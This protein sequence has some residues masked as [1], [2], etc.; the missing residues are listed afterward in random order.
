MLATVFYYPSVCLYETNFPYEGGH[1]I[2]RL[3]FKTCVLH[4]KDHFGSFFNTKVVEVAKMLL[5]LIVVGSYH[6]LRYKCKTTHCL[7]SRTSEYISTTV[8]GDNEKL[9]I[10]SARGSNWCWN[11][12]KYKQFSQSLQFVTMIEL[13]NV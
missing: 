1:S 8:L 9:L 6:F 12:H 5:K 13:K 7:D 10:S 11:F 4:R 2:A 3:V